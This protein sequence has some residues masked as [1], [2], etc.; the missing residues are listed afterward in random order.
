LVKNHQLEPT[1]PL[2]GAPVGVTLLEF[3]QHLWHQQTIEFTGYRMAFLS[4]PTF[5]YITGM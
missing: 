5:W 2:F 4:D 3:C 1:P